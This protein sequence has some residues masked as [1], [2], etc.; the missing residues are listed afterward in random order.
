MVKLSLG[1]IQLCRVEIRS[2]P[3]F[4]ILKY[5]CVRT[6]THTH[7]TGAVCNVRFC[8]VTG[9][10]TL[11]NYVG[12]YGFHSTYLDD[13]I[14]SGQQRGKVRHGGIPQPALHSREGRLRGDFHPLYSYSAVG[15]DCHPDLMPLRL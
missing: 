1:I 13:N 15:L 5:V 8:E 11:C 7:A 3:Y 9:F 12:S 4:M 6:H 2:E 14:Q 10:I